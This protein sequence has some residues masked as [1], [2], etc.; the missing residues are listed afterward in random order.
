[1]Y[2]A[3]NLP[4]LLEAIIIGFSATLGGIE[5][6]LMLLVLLELA[7]VRGEYGPLDGPLKNT[8]VPREEEKSPPVKIDLR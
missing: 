7:F 5:F 2:T 4:I 1:M 3:R 8:G 6:K